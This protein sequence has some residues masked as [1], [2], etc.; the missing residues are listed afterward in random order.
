MR[1]YVQILGLVVLAL[2][3]GGWGALVAAVLCPHANSGIFKPGAAQSMAA[4]YACHPVKVETR[5]KPHCHEEG[6]AEQAEGATVDDA[7][8]NAIPGNTGSLALDLPQ[9]VPCTHCLSRP[10]VPASTITA[11]QQSEQRRS[12]EPAVLQSAA[13]STPA[14]SFAGTV[15]YRQGAPPGSYTPKHLLI[16]ILL[17]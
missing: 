15:A 14:Q 3:A 5:R 17:I 6:M 7:S 11:R 10:E 1:R 4:D 16:G 9:N 12:L 13:P 2:S 8:S